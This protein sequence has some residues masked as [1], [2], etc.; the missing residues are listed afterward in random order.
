MLV[1]VLSAFSIL[2][3]FL[4]SF[5]GPAELFELA[6]ILVEVDDRDLAAGV[7]VNVTVVEGIT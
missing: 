1:V 3:S 4:F 6:L 5:K 2:V 7:V